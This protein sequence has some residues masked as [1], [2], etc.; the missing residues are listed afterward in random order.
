M[1]IAHAVMGQNRLHELKLV[2]ARMRSHVDHLIYV[3]GGSIDDSIL[4]ARNEGLDVVLSPWSDNFPAQRNKYVERARELGVEFL[5]VSD[6]DE[7]YCEELARSVRSLSEFAVQCDFT[8]YLIRSVD[9]TMLG[10]RE[11]SR[12]D[13]TG[14]AAW[15]KPLAFRI[16]PGMRYQPA[17]RGPLEERAPVHE[18]IVFGEGETFKAFAP[19]PDRFWYEH[20]KQLGALAVRGARNFYIG[21]GGDNERPQKWRDFRSIIS[22]TWPGTLPSWHEFERAMIAD[23]I[24]W[25]VEEWIDAHRHDDERGGDSEVRELYLYF[26]RILHPERDQHPGEYIK[27][28]EIVLP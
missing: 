18:E 28:Q 17:G 13:A 19:L 15:R 11:H 20:R 1:K 21:G 24:G 27:G 26:F 10:E 6:T 12:R 16:T 5:W 8:G 14:E 7:V 3:D 22:R 9:V 25:Q 2:V 4:W 23:R